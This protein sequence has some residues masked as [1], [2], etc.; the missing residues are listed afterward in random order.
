MKQ[1]Q[2]FWNPTVQCLY[3]YY[4]PIWYC[5]TIRRQ[6]TAGHVG[7][8]FTTRVGTTK[9]LPTLLARSSREQDERERE[10]FSLREN[11]QETAD[12]D[13]ILKL[14][15]Y[16]RNTWVFIL[17]VLQ[18]RARDELQVNRNNYYW[19]GTTAQQQVFRKRK[20][21]KKGNSPRGEQKGG[22]LK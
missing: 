5:V 14:E 2:D 10:R 1:S 4:S 3:N 20:V 8:V 18:P 11:R 13:S 17:K 9:V 16:L 7:E 22:V 19:R 12:S 15:N 21:Y 6:V